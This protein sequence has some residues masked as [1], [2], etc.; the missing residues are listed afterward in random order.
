MSQSR[1]SRVA[2]NRPA[3]ALPLPSGHTPAKPVRVR[4][5]QAERSA[6]TQRDLINA[7]VACLNEVGYHQATVEAVVARAKVSRG[8]VQHHFGSRDD[9][10][11]AV[12]ED[13]GRALSVDVP[14]PHTLSLEE[15]V[16]A[17]VQHNW[18]ILRSAQFVA[19]IQIWLAERANQQL[20]PTIQKS[21]SLV[22][23]Q[24]DR[25]WVET[26]SDLP[27]SSADLS[28]L[29]HV[30]LA[31]LRGLALRNIYRGRQAT[32]AREIE[33]VKAMVLHMLTR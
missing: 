7:A 31:S 6:S 25:R 5:P 28:A 3:D 13:L 9:L 16:D 11:L 27:L 20:F 32:W 21:V 10:I 22:E 24:L 18:K 15:R 29:R 12:V 1:R 4:R 8:A 14:I 19:V 2:A 26:F 23:E 30:V 17:I 33:I